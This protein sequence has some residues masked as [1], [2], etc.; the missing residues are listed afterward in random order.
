LTRLGAVAPRPRAPADP[1]HRHHADHLRPVRTRSAL[2]EQG[3]RQPGEFVSMAL[4]MTMRRWRESYACHPVAER[5]ALNL[6]V[7]RV[8]QT[9]PRRAAPHMTHPTLRNLPLL[10][11]VVLVAC[12]G[13]GDGSID[14]P[15][16]MSAL[17]TA[18][19]TAPDDLVPSLVGMVAVTAYLL[20]QS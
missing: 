10:V 6:P 11:L 17:P 20:L 3:A 15:P 14:N 9:V 2:V 1:G 16:P 13:G 5:R 12:G 7:P 4:A 8:G 18:T 19:L